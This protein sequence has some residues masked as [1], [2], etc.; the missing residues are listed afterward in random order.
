MVTFFYTCI[1]V[2]VRGS[3]FDGDKTE[4]LK[5]RALQLCLVEKKGVSERNVYWN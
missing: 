1:H 5:I 4:F 3:K 2:L